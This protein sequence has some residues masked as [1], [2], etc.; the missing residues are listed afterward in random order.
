MIKT[1][2]PEELAARV[3]NPSEAGPHLKVDLSDATAV[4]ALVDLADRNQQHY[5]RSAGF[6]APEVFLAYPDRF[7]PIV[8]ARL[9]A[10]GIVPLWGL[11]RELTD[12]EEFGNGFG[13]AID[14]IIGVGGVEYIPASVSA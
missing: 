11:S 7:V 5:E 8:V 13:P 2:S 3:A 1:L 9:L 4:I 14:L 10:Y 6:R 12:K